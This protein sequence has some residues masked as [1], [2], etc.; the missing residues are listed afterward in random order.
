MRFG[1]NQV[2]SNSIRISLLIWFCF[3]LA[4]VQA[5]KIEQN[6][7]KPDSL[8]LGDRFYLSITS[9]IDLSDV[10][11][12]DTLT[13]FVV[14]DKQKIKDKN[15]ATGLKL[16]ISPLDTGEHTFPSLQVLPLKPLTD[17]LL[18]TAFPVIINEIRP[19]QDS[20]LADIAPTHKLKGELPYWAY[21]LILAMVVLALIIA[22]F[23]L[24]KKYRKKQELQAPQTLV[25][26]DERPNWKQALDALYELKEQSLPAKGDFILYHYRLSEIMKLFLEAEYHFSANE[27]T[28]K[29]IKAFLKKHNPISITDQ[30]AVVAWLE[31]CDLVKFAKHEPSVAECDEKLD[32]MVSWLL[33]I[34]RQIEQEKQGAPD[35]N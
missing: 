27:M 1:L 4:S 10:I 5:V 16:A 19:A 3:L 21:Y 17:S 2:N 31:S 25:P 15:K 9:D 34:S 20:T 12:P 28:S 18:T 30:R 13:K 22:L 11:I 6:V 32:W 14:L 33:Q 8:H 26:R 23:L 35:G 7:Q 29:E 24:W